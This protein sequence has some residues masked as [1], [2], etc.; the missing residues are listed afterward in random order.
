MRDRI[1]S[2]IASYVVNKPWWTLLWIMIVTVICMGMMGQLT[3][4]T[5]Y[6]DMMPQD[7]PSIIELNTISEE[8]NATSTLYIVAEGDGE[9]LRA[10]AE[11]A[12]PLVEGLEQYI[13]SVIYQAPR[14]FIAEHALML[15]KSNDLENSRTLFE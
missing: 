13:T 5:E 9:D 2:A 6:Q 1:L 8:Y 4:S 10:F 14:D 15:M 12:I 11:E 7:D 3:I